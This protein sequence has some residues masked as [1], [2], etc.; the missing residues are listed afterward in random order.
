[1]ANGTCTRPCQQ[2]SDCQTA[3][4]QQHN[5]SALCLARESWDLDAEG[6][7]INKKKYNSCGFLCEYA[8]QTYTCPPA[9]TCQL[10]SDLKT[11]VPQ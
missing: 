2:N 1:M 10:V 9:H 8:G 5:Y 6:N 3:E 11:C 4:S 7:I